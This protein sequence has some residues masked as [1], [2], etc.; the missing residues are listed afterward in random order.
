M[1][2]DPEVLKFLWIIDFPL[3]LVN[4]DTGELESAHH[5][6]TRCCILTNFDR[7]FFS[8]SFLYFITLHLPE[9]TT[10]YKIHQDLFKYWYTLCHFA[11]DFPVN[12]KEIR[13]SFL[14]CMYLGSYKAK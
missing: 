11:M 6:F 13:E 14:F 9:E 4:E 8:L 5:P 1:N 7:F 10:N 3:F 2:L 12:I